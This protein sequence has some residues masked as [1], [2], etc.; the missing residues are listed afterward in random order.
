MSTTWAL[1][2]VQRED[3]LTRVTANICA[4]AFA[5]GVM[6]AAEDARVAATSI[7]RKAYTTAQVA[8]NVTTGS[9]PTAETTESYSRRAAGAGGG[10][11]R[12]VAAAQIRSARSQICPQPGLRNLLRVE[13][14]PLPARRRAGS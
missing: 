13:P 12:R 8:S 7:E 5:K 10:A 11:G 6:V 9:R 3:V 4:L 2:A 1:S 14:P